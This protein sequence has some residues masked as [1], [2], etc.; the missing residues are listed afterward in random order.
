MRKLSG[1]PYK[2][3][4]VLG[5]AK[6]GTAAATLLLANH[7]HVRVNDYKAKDTDLN[8]KE[9]MQQGAELILGSHPLSVLKGIDYII[10]NP[11]ISYKNPILIEAEKRNIP[12]VTEIELAANLAAYN[13]IIAITGSNGKTTT[14]TLVQEMLIQSNQPVQLAGNIGVVATDVAQHLLE[15][16]ALLLELSS[17]QLMGV[18][19]FRP[20]VA[21]LLN[22]FDA[23]LDF[24]GSLDNYVA[25]KANIFKNQT[26]H[27]FLIYN[28]DDGRVCTVIQNAKAKLVPFSI[29]VRQPDGAWADEKAIYFKNIRIMEKENIALVGEH[30][31]QNILAAL[32]IA[33]MMGATKEGIQ[34]V[35]ATFTG[36]KHRLQFVKEYQGRLFYNDSKATN[37]LATEKALQSF[38]QPTIL[39]A[40]G[41]DRGDMF[42]ELRPYLSQVK[43]MI[44]FGET[45]EKL[46]Q[47]A[48]ELNIQTVLVSDVKE[49]TT[50]AYQYSQSG[51]VILLS[52]ACASWDQY[53]TFE[54]RG[55]MF[56][57]AVHRLA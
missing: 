42:T 2:H 46:Q 30:N 5:L 15:K 20:H 39:L 53:K 23:H 51:D 27:D 33:M 38:K 1:F 19:S 18:T 57:Q 25:A 16:E 28:A 34:A 54:E 6:S 9:L 17:F 35:L 11:G 14:T 3:V 32:S 31:I 8:V 37:M 10:K 22:L 52:P 24:H 21:A 56:I 41:L 48:H 49:A 55:D 50:V 7:K 13:P 47:V 29:R 44:L 40:G 43:A 36:V 45:K 12:I 26:E 4:L